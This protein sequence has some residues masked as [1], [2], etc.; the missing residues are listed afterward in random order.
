MDLTGLI[1][2]IKHDHSVN[3]IGMAITPLQAT[4]IDAVISYLRNNGVKPKGYILMAAHPGTGRILNKKNFSTNYNDIKFVDFDCEFY[5][6][7]GFMEQLQV[8]IHGLLY[9]KRNK[10]GKAIYLVWTEVFT[11]LMYVLS[12]SQPESNITFIQIDDGAASY[13]NDFHLRLSN[14]QLGGTNN[15]RKIV[16]QYLKAGIYSILSQ[17]MRKNLKQKNKYITATIFTKK[18]DEKKIKLEQNQIIVPYYV[19]AFKQQKFMNSEMLKYENAIVVNTQCLSEGHITNGIVD[20]EVYQLF[21][22][23]IKGLKNK[24]ILKPHPREK[25]TEKY[26][27]LGWELV[28]DK[29]LTQESILACLE[30]KPK[31]IISIYSSTLLN[32]RGLFGI[33]AISLAKLMLRKQIS[34]S[35]RIELNRYIKMYNSVIYFPSTE[36]ELR[37]IIKNIMEKGK[38]V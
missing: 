36:L 23:A 16:V 31:C 18:I 9:T 22:E 4:G 26:Q 38:D 32:A 25:D 20:L 24:I 11:N 30:N 6:K 37:N 35:L 21:T 34:K 17:L 3:F 7:Q 13:I 2:K 1:E 27:R 19:E 29:S 5:N 14:L 8:K 10:N 15:A 33:P 12:E 28:N